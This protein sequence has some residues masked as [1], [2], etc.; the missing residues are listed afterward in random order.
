MPC[1]FTPRWD[2]DTLIL[3][4]DKLLSRFTRIAIH[5]CKEKAHNSTVLA[6]GKWLTSRT[7]W[8]HIVHG[9][10]IDS[11]PLLEMNSIALL[12]IVDTWDELD[13]EALLVA[14][15]VL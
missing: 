11:L 4:A 5:P 14:W 3:A 15:S 7:L 8:I 13:R 6:A 2:Q 9:I 10:K 12:R 1:I